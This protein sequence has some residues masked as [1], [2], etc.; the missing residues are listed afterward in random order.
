MPD[1]W[2]KKHQCLREGNA[3]CRGGKEEI[4]KCNQLRR[5]LHFY[6]KVFIALYDIFHFFYEFLLFNEASIQKKSGSCVWKWN[7]LN[8]SS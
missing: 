7:A 2:K 1:T 4:N 6:T 3:K 5:L 8:R